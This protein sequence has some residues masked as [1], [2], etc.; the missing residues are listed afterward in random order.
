MNAER[1][2]WIVARIAVVAWFVAILTLLVILCGRVCHASGDSQVAATYLV[3]DAQKIPLGD[4]PGQVEWSRPAAYHEAVVWVMNPVDSGA[5][6]GTVLACADRAGADVGIVITAQHIFE[7]PGGPAVIQFKHGRHAGQSIRGRVLLA[8]S[9]HDLAAVTLK[10][11]PDVHRLKVAE[12]PLMAGDRAEVCGYGAG[13]W[14]PRWASVIGYAQENRTDG[15]HPPGTNVLIRD[16]S[17]SGDSGGPILNERAEL[18]GVLWGFAFDWGQESGPTRGSYS[19]IVRDQLASVG[20]V[21]KASAICPS[22]GQTSDCPNCP[23]R[24]LRPIQRPPRLMP[25][26]PQQTYPNLP[27]LSPKGPETSPP[28][29][30]YPGENTPP[31]TPAA[32]TPPSAAQPGPAI[33]QPIVITR[34]PIIFADPPAQPD[35]SSAGQPSASQSP[36]SAE[37]TAKT[38]GAWLGGIAGSG[39]ANLLLAGLAG[40]GA[41]VGLPP[42]VSALARPLVSRLARQ[43]GQQVGGEVGG[44]AEQ[45]ARRATVRLETAG[46]NLRE[47]VHANQTAIVPIDREGDA[48]SRAIKLYTERRPEADI[49]FRNIQRIKDL[50]LSGKDPV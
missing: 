7:Q 47:V 49:H 40:A 4:P 2:F 32:P 19:K 5:G 3:A 9:R 31:P 44:V 38:W 18:A 13:H 41:A 12:R 50:I 36:S 35:R 30:T 10:I 20:V 43:V 27:Q 25:A 33:T 24:P 14:R 48:Y 11:P 6:T 15:S 34:P 1:F 26:T 39:A 28:A 42:L 37:A 45:V 17:I 23:L 29:V 22:D 8:S 21:C 46:Q 16:Q